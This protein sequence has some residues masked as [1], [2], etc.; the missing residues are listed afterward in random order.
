MRK[1]QSIVKTVNVEEP[2][3]VVVKPAGKS[4][5]HNKSSIKLS[6]DQYFYMIKVGM[7]G[8]T[9][10]SFIMVSS[11]E[12][13]DDEG[14]KSITEKIKKELNAR[15]IPNFRYEMINNPSF[16]TTHSSGVMSTDDANN[17]AFKKHS[18]V[19]EAILCDH[20]GFKV[21]K[22]AGSASEIIE[23][24]FSNDAMKQVHVPKELL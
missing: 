11:E 24:T 1:S 14:L 4:K 3:S 17:N 20:Y 9:I 10:S 15:I 8:S 13:Y 7:I 19:F 6:T 22:P 16:R 21:I 2:K 12:R 23:P 18:E 5:T